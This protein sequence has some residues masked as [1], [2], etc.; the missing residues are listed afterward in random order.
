MS[1]SDRGPLF[2]CLVAVDAANEAMFDLHKAEALDAVIIAANQIS[3][4]F[5]REAQHIQKREGSS[6]REDGPSVL[7]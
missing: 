2:S 4:L 5:W 1:P 6:I 3:R 7:E